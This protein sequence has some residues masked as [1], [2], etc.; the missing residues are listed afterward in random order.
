MPCRK[1]AASSPV[2]TA[3]TRNP[4]S[5]SDIRNGILKAWSSPPTHTRCGF[6]L[7]LL[8]VRRTR[9]AG[10]GQP[11]ILLSWSWFRYFGACDARFTV[12]AG[13][14]T[15]LVHLNEVGCVWIAL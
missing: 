2:E 11:L 12:G 9:L 1:N 15:V 5:R 3:V 4:F 6:I 14:P 7:P 10:S 8:T 13:R